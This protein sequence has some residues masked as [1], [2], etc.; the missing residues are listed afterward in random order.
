MG[1]VPDRIC[2]ISLISGKIEGHCPLKF[3]D[4]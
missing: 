4:G 1:T 2:Q 3:G